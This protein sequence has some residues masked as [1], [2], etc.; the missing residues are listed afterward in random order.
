[1]AE[2]NGQLTTGSSGR[3]TAA[4]EPERSAGQ[5]FA[6]PA[7]CGAHFVRHIM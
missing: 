5:R 2:K 1:M 4:A 7:E 6:C 3:L